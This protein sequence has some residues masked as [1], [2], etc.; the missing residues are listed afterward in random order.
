MQSKNTQNEEQTR[1]GDL[2]A[3][4]FRR[5]FQKTLVGFCPEFNQ[6]FNFGWIPNF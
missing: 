2:C 6:F 4:R 1:L 5:A 3:K